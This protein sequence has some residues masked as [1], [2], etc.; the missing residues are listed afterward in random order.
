[1]AINLATDYGGLKLKNPIVIGARQYR[2][3]CEQLG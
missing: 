2:D 1:M 3:R